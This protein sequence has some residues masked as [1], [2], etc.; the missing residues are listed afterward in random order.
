[1]SNIIADLLATH[2]AVAFGDFI[3]ASGERSTYY[4]DVKVAATHPAVLSAVGTMI[5]GAFRFEQVAGVAV[6]GIPLA[7]S[8]SL[9]SGRPYAIIRAVAKDHGRGGLVIGDVEGREVLLVEDVTTSGGS[10]LH[11]VRALREAG[12]TVT[13]VVTVVDREAGA[14]DALAREGVVLHA[15][16]LGSEVLASA[17]QLSSER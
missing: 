8:V 11:G 6:G 13:E 3:L 15:L 10:S 9:A 16:A 12:A 5:V 1:M 2:G 17:T 14:W 7:V 4:L